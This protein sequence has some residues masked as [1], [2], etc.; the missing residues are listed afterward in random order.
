MLRK[1]TRKRALVALSVVAVLATAGAALAFFTS[2]G[3]GTGSASVGS[4]TSFTVAVGTA[5]GGPLTPGS[6]SQTLSYTVTNPGSGS[7][8]LSGT[9]AVV[10]SSGLNIKSGG[11]AVPGC[12][13]ADFTV[14][15]NKPTLPQN[16]AGGAT[17]TPGSVTVTMQDSGVNQDPCQGKT[18]DITVSAS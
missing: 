7:Q 12:L 10:A 4:S 17:S 3:S 13:A 8:N 16:L 11:T 5:T 9:S 14:V 2:S 15:N 18:P 1:F 6:G